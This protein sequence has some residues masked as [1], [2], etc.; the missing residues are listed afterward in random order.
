MLFCLCQLLRH[1]GAFQH[2]LLRS[3]RCRLTTLGRAPHKAYREQTGERHPTYSPE[4][5]CHHHSLEGSCLRKFFQCRS[6][7]T[8]R[9]SGR[10]PGDPRSM[11]LRYSAGTRPLRL[12]HLLSLQVNDD[13]SHALIRGAAALRSPYATAL[14]QSK[15]PCQRQ[16]IKRKKVIVRTQST[17]VSS[18]Q[19][20]RV[21]SMAK[22]EIRPEKHEG[23]RE[24]GSA[25]FVL[26]R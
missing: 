16:E 6:P 23:P 2:R 9:F 7:Q 24:G 25:G 20:P 17:K 18:P 1:L 13:P 15:S 22:Q 4:F 14:F 5:H 21:S 19:T 8:G 10:Q 12:C 11:T 26:W 3:G